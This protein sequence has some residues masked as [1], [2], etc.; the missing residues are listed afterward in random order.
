VHPNLLYTKM[1][2]QHQGMQLL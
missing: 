1:K 2:M